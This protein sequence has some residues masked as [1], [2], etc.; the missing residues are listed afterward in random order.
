MKQLVGMV[1]L[2]AV[3]AF[4]QAQSHGSIALR[5]GRIVTV[6]GPVLEKGTVLLRN[7]LIE[8]VGENVDL[9]KDAWIVDAQGLTIYPGLID[10]LSTVSLS[11]TP[12]QQTSPPR[13]SPETP[14]GRQ[15]PQMPLEQGPEFRPFTTTWVRAADLVNSADRRIEETRS[16]GFTSVVA[17]PSSGIFAGQGALLNLSGEKNGRMIVASP[18]GQ[19]LTLATHGFGVYPGSLMGVLAYIRQLVLDAEHYKL[20]RQA[21]DK[22]PPGR[23]RPNYDRAVEGLLDSPRL[24]LPANSAVQIERM[25][26]FVKELEHP[27]VLYGG[28]AGYRVAD[29]VARSSIPVLINLKWPE[30]P[31]DADPDEQDSLRTLELRDQAPSTPAVLQ[32]AGARFAFYSGGT[33][34]KDVRKAVRRAIDAGLAESDAVRAL[35]LSAAEIYG[36]ANHLGSI[37]PGKIAN[38]LVASGSLFDDKTKIEYV[39]IDGVKYEPVADGPAGDRETRSVAGGLQ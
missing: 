5:G 35:T 31:K 39:F 30:R 15:E 27:A 26:R 25:L 17:F 11:E 33:A 8:T 29:Q 12:A 1:L 16:Q 19:Y 18:A 28:H 13:P 38:L 6:S 32:K 7:G 9:P 37:E 23:K 4:L 14:F 10:S 21:Y 2:S 3:P 34:P 36:V 24:L 22:D 20:E